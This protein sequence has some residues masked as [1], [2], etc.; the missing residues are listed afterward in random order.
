MVDEMMIAWLSNNL[1]AGVSMLLWL[2]TLGYNVDGDDVPWLSRNMSTYFVDFCCD[3]YETRMKYLTAL[4]Q[5]RHLDESP[6]APELPPCPAFVDKGD[7]HFLRGRAYA[8]YETRVRRVRRSHPNFEHRLTLLNAI[9]GLKKRQ[10]VIPLVVQQEAVRSWYK[11]L[12]EPRESALLGDPFLEKF[13][14]KVRE[15]SKAMRRKLNDV[16]V[17]VPTLSTAARIEMGTKDGGA[18]GAWLDAVRGTFECPLERANLVQHAHEQGKRVDDFGWTTDPY[19]DFDTEG[20]KFTLF[21]SMPCAVDYLMW[22]PHGLLAVSPVALPE[23][24]KVRLISKGPAVDY[25]LS[26]VLQKM[27]HTALQSLP[28]FRLTRESPDR[29]I[30]DVMSSNF[31]LHRLLHSSWSHRP[32]ERTLMVS[33]DYKGATDNLDPLVSRIVVWELCQAAGVSRRQHELFRDALVGHVA[34]VPSP[35]GP[36]TKDQQ[37]GQLMGSPASFPVLCIANWALTAAAL[38][39]CEGQ[40]TRPA[41]TSGITINGD[42]I[43]FEALPPAIANWRRRT[44]QGGLTPS[45]GKNFVSSQ[46]VQINSKMLVVDDTFCFQVTLPYSRKSE[47]SQ[48]GPAQDELR[49]V[50][51][52][53]MGGYFRCL[54]NASLAVLAPPRPVSFAEFCLSAPGWAKTFLSSFDTAEKDRLMSLFTEHW[55]EYLRRLPAGLMNWFVPRE[56]GGFG[57][58]AT[59]EVTMNEGQ[60]RAAAWMRDNTDAETARRAKLVWDQPG[61]STTVHADATKV[62]NLLREQGLIEW[63]WAADSREVEID[64]SP[65]EQVCQL[66]CWSHPVGYSAANGLGSRLLPPWHKLAPAGTV[67]SIGGAGYEA[68][69]LK[70]AQPSPADRA[71][72]GPDATNPQVEQRLPACA[73]PRDPETPAPLPD[74]RAVWLQRSIRFLQKAARS[75]SRMM[76]PDDIKSW[77]PRRAGWFPAKGVTVR[78]HGPVTVR[79]HDRHIVGRRGNTAFVRLL[80]LSNRTRAPIILG[81]FTLVSI[82]PPQLTGDTTPCP[83]LF[84]IAD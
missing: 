25:W 7:T 64:F 80:A 4:V 14:E 79:A 10:P 69:T 54:P 19:F 46:F 76:T 39:E 45:V 84:P 72:P 61:A 16:V 52:T 40:R 65:I 71:T 68:C 58:P 17:R 63:R 50:K 8:W 12:F 32:R 48:F 30:E 77:V 11:A 38:E 1:E 13:R 67:D 5:A 47:W 24:F 15:A 53:L 83:E 62:V 20:G 75:T 21:G 27:V 43:A 23:P 36:T 60:Q 57:L 22:S 3:R 6:G 9:T 70:A 33:G 74:E 41:G 18:F 51:K 29:T 37:W 35:Q 31:A 55:G 73:A 42:D 78:S 28:E 34:E 2:Q 59:R 26:Q 82:S 66:S 49:P 81:P 44:A 56:L